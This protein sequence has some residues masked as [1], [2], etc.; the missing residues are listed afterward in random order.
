[1]ELATIIR[2]AGALLAVLAL[3]IGALIFW[4]YLS[5]RAET[6]RMQTGHKGEK[7]IR[8]VE[9]RVLDARRRIVIVR[10]DDEE[11]AVLLGHERDTVLTHLSAERDGPGREPDHER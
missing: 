3:A 10:I 5:Q 2:A 8:V 6:M 7:R 9:T 1:M 4:R 11:M